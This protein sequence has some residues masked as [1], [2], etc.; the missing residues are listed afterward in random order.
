MYRANIF[1]PTLV[2]EGAHAG[3]LCVFLTLGEG[4][5]S[6]EAQIVARLLAM[7]TSKSA[8]VIVTGDH[9]WDPSLASAI[10]SA[11]FRVHME[12]DGTRPVLGAVDWLTIAPN[13]ES[14]A[15]L[16]KLPADEIRVV[17]DDRVDEAVLDRHAARWRCE[18]Y[19]VRPADDKQPAR[20]LAM[21]QA[22]PR[23]RLSLQLQKLV[24]LP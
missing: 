20:T 16:D 24:G 18:H 10:R 17:V 9:A 6:T 19:F 23:W 3:R 12:S 14:S 13:P 7:D 5:S 8:R 4:E 15:V 21:I 1:G 2:G 11:G 22:R